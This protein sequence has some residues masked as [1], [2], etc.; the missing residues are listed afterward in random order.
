MQLSLDLNLGIPVIVGVENALELFRDGQEITVD[1]S[2][3]VIYNG[4]ASVL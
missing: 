4:H 2:R 3:G 1:A